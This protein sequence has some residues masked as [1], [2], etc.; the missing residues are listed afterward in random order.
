QP[1]QALLRSSTGDATAMVHRLEDDLPV[2]I[3]HLTALA[4]VVE[5]V[6]RRPL[7]AG[8]RVEPLVNGDAAYP[9]MLEA[10]AKAKETITLSTYIFDRDEAG[11]A[12]AKTLGEAVRR[13]VNVRVLIDATGTRYSW[14]PILGTLRHEQVPYARFL[15]TFRLWRLMAMNLRSHRKI[16]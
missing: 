7:I 12:F 16:L 2:E 13:G 15:P 3:R 14:P 5:T 9:A 8:N 4:R 11:L 6:A 1:A 10:M